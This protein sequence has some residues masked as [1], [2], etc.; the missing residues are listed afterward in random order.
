M[1]NIIDNFKENYYFR[2]GLRFIEKAE[3]NKARYYFEKAFLLN[4][5]NN[6]ITFYLGL[7]LMLL[8]KYNEA[9]NYFERIP[10]DFNNP[11]MLSSMGFSFLMLRKW[12]EARDI[13]AKLLEI[14]PKNKEYNKFHKLSMDVIKREKFVL[15]K[16][17]MAIA[18]NLMK[19]K[20]YEQAFD[21]L[22][23]AKNLVPEDAEIFNYLGIASI[24]LKKAPIEIYSF[25][26]KAVILDPNNRGYKENLF[27]AKKKLKKLH[28]IQN[29]WIFRPNI[30]I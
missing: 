16:E 7:S 17:K 21:T 22:L 25:F 5:K 15:M 14:N 9:L 26:E 4:P 18:D 27:L 1:F 11:L 2:R 8:F 6:D 13:F 23:D 12:A 28:S 10:Q 3:Y 24:Q 19:N 29:I 20:D 30:Q